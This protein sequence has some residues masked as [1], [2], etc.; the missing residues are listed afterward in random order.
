MSS[1]D[2][3]S[4]TTAA[5]G[6]D[7]TLDR[8]GVEQRSGE[9]RRSPRR[10]TRSV[11]VRHGAGAETG[12]LRE[13][14]PDPVGALP[15]RPELAQR[16]LVHP[17]LRIDEPL[18][19]ER[20]G[21]CGRRGWRVIGAHG[22]SVG[23]VACRPE[24]WDR[25]T[26]ARSRWSCATCTSARRT[27]AGTSRRGCW[28]RA[29]SCDGASSTSGRRRRDRPRRQ[30]D[31]APGRPP[32]DR[33]GPAHLRSRRPGRRGHGAGRAGMDGGGAGFGTPEGPAAVL[34]DPS[35]T[36]IAL[37]GWTGRRRW[38]PHASADNTHAVR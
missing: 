11:L 7:R 6:L 5:T 37:L 13:D 28:S 12:Q 22:P 31:G 35:G 25:P 26:Y 30:A 24:A 32:P 36:E 20:I 34:R 29:R 21:R 19:S 9:G 23:P 15:A 4:A 16:P 18:Q 33:L 3:P 38:R 2:R 17:V 14:E 1:T 27:P 10:A 8:A